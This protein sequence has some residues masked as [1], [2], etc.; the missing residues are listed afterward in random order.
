MPTVTSRDGTKIAFDKVGSGPAVIMVNGAI[1][2][3]A[4]DPTMGQIAERLSKNFT[5]FNY[6]RRG[7]G[8]SGD[9][10]PFTKDREIEDIQ[11]LIADAGGN[12]MGFGISSGAVL[13]LDAAA[14]TPA[15]TKLFL[16]EPPFIVDDSRKPV[17]A[18]YAEHLMKL[19]LEGKRDE[20]AE[21]FLIHAVGIPPEYVGGAK[22]DQANWSAMTRAAHTIAYDA[23]YVSSVM[24]GKSLP[25]DRWNKVVVPVMV[26]DGGGSDAWMHNAADALAKVLPHAN[27]QTLAGQTHMVAPDVIAPVIAEFFK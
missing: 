24:Q 13:T 23:S 22:Q 26:V 20:A 2:H 8:E 14:V 17:P 19:S 11:A 1:A 27:R 10:R 5:V 21:Y 12:A 7:R 3:R 18:D 25:T 4:I 9:T 16:Y 6:D 15:I